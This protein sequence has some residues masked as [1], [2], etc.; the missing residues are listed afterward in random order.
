M[1]EILEA[2]TKAVKD[3]EKGEP[4]PTCPLPWHQFKFM[5][6]TCLC[7]EKKYGEKL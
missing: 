1:G 5:A 2:L 4:K 3:L 7:G 6:P